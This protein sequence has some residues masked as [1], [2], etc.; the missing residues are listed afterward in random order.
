MLPVLIAAALAAPPTPAHTV[1]LWPGKAPGETA[2]LPAEA[3][4]PGKPGQITVARLGN[5]SV[6]QVS[7]YPAARPNGACVIVAPGGGYSILAIEH[8]GTD[9]AAWL[10]TIGVTAVVLKYRVPRRPGQTPDNLAALQDAQRAVGLVR[11]NAK[12]WGIDPNRVGFLGFSAGGH[13]TASLVASA[14][15]R[16]YEAVDA[17]DSQPCRPSFAVMVYAG[18]LTEKG[19]AD[20]K[21]AVAVTKANPPTLLV[22]ATD[23]NSDQSVAYY[24]ALLANKVPAELHLYEGGGHGFGMRKDKGATSDWPARAADWMKGRGLLAG[25]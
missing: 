12:D 16:V 21:P 2:D 15:K 3:L 9:V 11:Q 18:G 8:E 10:N 7:V 25:K 1:N 22:H 14:D 19:K 23:D 5:V 4:Q 17:A 6:P 13:L 24:R 20:L